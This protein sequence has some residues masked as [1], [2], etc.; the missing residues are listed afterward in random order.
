[1]THVEDIFGSDTATSATTDSGVL[2]DGKLDV[3]N[4]SI[5]STDVDLEKNG[6]KDANNSSTASL[7]T[8]FEV[9]EVGSNLVESW[10]FQEV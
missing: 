6:R 2:R 3:V 9:R 5:V 10:T 1:M 7:A 4:A 8:V